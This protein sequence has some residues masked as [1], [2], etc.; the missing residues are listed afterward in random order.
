MQVRKLIDEQLDAIS[1]LNWARL[2]M[3]LDCEGCIYV[4]RPDKRTRSMQ[5]KVIVGNTDA[6]LPQWLYETFGGRYCCCQP[7]RKPNPF[8]DWTACGPYA[9]VLLTRVLPYLLLKREQAS[10]FLKL[11]GTVK[12]HGPQHITPPEIHAQRVGLLA[13]LRSHKST[14]GGVLLN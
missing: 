3:A 6:R 2:A 13:E 1:S 10:I 8:W 11:R 7:N 9:A 12:W 4:G 14:K 5:F